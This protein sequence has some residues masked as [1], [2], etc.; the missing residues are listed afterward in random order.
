MSSTLCTR[1]AGAPIS[2]GVCEVAGWGHQLGPDRV[3][4]EMQAVGL[5]ATECGPVGF[6]PE[7]PD[8][9]R[10]VL[11]AHGLAVVGGFLPLVMHD[12]IDHSRSL[13]SVMRGFLAAGASTLVLA[14]ATGENGYDS[15]PSLEAS[16]WDSLLR[17]LDTAH[18]LARELG[19]TAVLHPHVGTVI[20]STLEVERV[21]AGSSI[22]LC[23]DTG[24]LLIGGTDPLELAKRAA[25]RIGHVHLKDV[26][27]DMADRVREGEVGYAAAVRDGLYTV[28]GRGDV[29][30]AG[31][32][33]ALESGG[34]RGWY[35]LEQDVAL[36]AE[37]AA[38]RGPATDVAACLEHL[39]SIAAD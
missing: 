29:D 12:G 34:Y 36:D 21:L 18:E 2:W 39:V 25:G 7:E 5:S 27:S 14:A 9:R 28:L 32:V 3:L 37:P 17:T 11:D 22:D 24:H 33:S 19:M 8:E 1:I 20:E 38:D 6:L 16:E 26:R 35:V 30:V 13:I 10:R 23:L 15:R 4:R 31:V